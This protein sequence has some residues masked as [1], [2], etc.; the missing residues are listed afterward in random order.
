MSTG[1]NPFQSPGAA[2]Q[3]SEVPWWN[4]PFQSGHRRAAITIALLMAIVI[5]SVIFLAMTVLEYLSLV[6]MA[7]GTFA[8]EQPRRKDRRQ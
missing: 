4:A 5:L 2:P 7:D 6:K 8:P 1:H 3:P